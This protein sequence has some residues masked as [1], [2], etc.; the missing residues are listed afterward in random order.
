MNRLRILPLIAALAAGSL[1]LTACDVSPYAAVVNGNTISVNSLTSQLAAFSSNKTFVQEFNQSEASQAQQSGSQP[2]TVAGSG[3]AGTYSSAF[4]ARVLGL[5]IQTTAIHQYLEAHGKQATPNQVLAARAVQEISYGP[6]WN[7]FPSSIQNIFVEQLADFGALTQ[8]PSDV[9]SLQ[10]PYSQL[11]PYLFSSI[12][13][14]RASAFNQD[15]ARAIASSGSLGGVQ[16]C[17]SQTDVERQ[18]PQLQSALRGLTTVGQVSDPVRTSY[19]YE[20]LKLVS[21][22]APGLTPG[23]ASVI[24]AYSNPPQDAQSIVTSAHVKVNPRYGSWVNGQVNP[25]ATL[26]S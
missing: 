17:Y 24:V 25:P 7:Q 18:S 8:A 19:G 14:D 2:V 12:C 21:R 23:V 20:V 10:N 22:D 13:V 1:T 3:G 9:S 15:A 6:V 11:Q 5:F 4:V 16:T 26:N